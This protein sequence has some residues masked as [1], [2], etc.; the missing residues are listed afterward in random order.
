[1]PPHS[2]HLL[3]PLDVSCFS[4]LKQL[5]R[6]AVQEQMQA[7]INYVDKDDLYLQACAASYSS[8]TIQSGFRATGL[9]PFNPDEVLSQLHIQ[10]KTP[11]PVQPVVAAPGPWVPETPDNIA[12]LDLQTKAVQ[13]LIRYRMQS[14][15][16]PTVQAINQLIK[17]CQMAMH[18][19][20]ILAAENKR[21]QTANEKVKK[22]RQ[23]KKSYVGKGGVLS[24][25]EV[26]EA[27]RGVV[28]EEDTTM[29]IVTQPSQLSF[30]CAPQLCSICR[31]LEH[32]ACTCPER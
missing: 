14:P 32:T 3:Q 5:Y 24:A 18:S 16:S 12:E 4:V 23:K 26:Q 11:S 20:T 22:K 27:Q 13:G 9:V 15:P 21:L 1:M 19:A 29:Q 7:G 25:A 28:I 31:S 2:S 8:S 6:L 10:L 30:T 17:G